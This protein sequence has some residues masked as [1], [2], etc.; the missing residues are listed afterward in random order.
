MNIINSTDSTDQN[1]IAPSPFQEITASEGEQISAEKKKNYEN[2]GRV[3]NYRSRKNDRLHSKKPV[4]GY[5][6]IIARIILRS[7]MKKLKLKDIYNELQRTH[8]FFKES[9]GKW[10]NSVRH[11]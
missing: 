5:I 7:K 9:K 6:K 2:K 10:Q 8:E 3:E 1:I 4:G 11:W